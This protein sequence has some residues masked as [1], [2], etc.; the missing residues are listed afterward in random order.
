MLIFTLQQN[1]SPIHNLLAITVVSI[2]LLTYLAVTKGVYKNSLPN[3]LEL[4]FLC[5][6]GLTSAAVQFELANGNQGRQSGV[7]IKIS[8]GVIFFVF[9]GIIFFHAPRR[10]LQTTF[11]AKMKNSIMTLISLK[12]KVSRDIQLPPCSAP[13]V[14]STLIELK[15]P[16]LEY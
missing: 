7:P 10:L 1:Y 6:L 13:Q 9:T 16:L 5:N 3:Y 2:G 8:T 12:K 4:F 15:E 14:T 11:G